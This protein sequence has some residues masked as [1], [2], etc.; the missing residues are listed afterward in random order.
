MRK[1]YRVAPE[2]EEDLDGI[3]WYVYE[4]SGSERIANT[5]IDDITGKFALIGDMPSLGRARN[6]VGIGVHSM[7]VRE[8]YTIYYQPRPR[9]G[10]IISRIIHGARD[11]KKAWK[12][13]AGE[14]SDS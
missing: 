12:R 2:A 1:P 11:Q 6:D 7:P 5:L 3:W 9:G 13:K 4:A 8:N 10:V 14:R